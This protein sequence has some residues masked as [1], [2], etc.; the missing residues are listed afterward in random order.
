MAALSINLG[1]AEDDMKWI[2]QTCS[3]CLTKDKI[4]A[5]AMCNN[6]KVN[7]PHPIF[8]R[9]CN[10]EKQL[11]SKIIPFM[12]IFSLPK[13]SQ[14][15]LKGQV[16]LV[17]SNVQNTANS[18]P[19]DTRDA[20]IIALNLKRR[21]SDKQTF[22]KEFIR[23]QLV[24]EAFQILKTT[25]KHYEQIHL[26]EKWVDNSKEHDEQL[27]AKTCQDPES[28]T[29]ENDTC[30]NNENNHESPDFTDSEDEVEKDIPLDVAEEISTKDH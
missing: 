8:N 7:E 19:R 11:I 20:Q 5:Q 25:N 13:G 24:N 9:M 22:C 15:G 21:L 10:L 16:V 18:L 2:C 30:E 23:P 27:W 17:P 4:P 6:L 1:L 3:S 28:D 26:N 29:I 12:K 14:Q